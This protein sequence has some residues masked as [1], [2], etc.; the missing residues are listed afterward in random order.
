MWH[1][2]L[3]EHNDAARALQRDALEQ[4]DKAARFPDM[5]ERAS[6]L[7]QRIRDSAQ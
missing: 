7:A 3:L 2:L 4:L 5:E 6:S 1:P